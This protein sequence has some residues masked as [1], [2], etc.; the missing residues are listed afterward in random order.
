MSV[1]LLSLT[2]AAEILDCSR[3]HM[4]GLIA[5]GQLRAVEIAAQGS[6]TKTR[7]RS[8]DLDEFIERKTRGA[9]RGAA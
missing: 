4:Y 7:I 2:T 9:K 8:D 6:R 1:R 5:A 3:T